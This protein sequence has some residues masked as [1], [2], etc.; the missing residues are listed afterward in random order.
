MM[1]DDE[2][3]DALL[4]VHEMEG[5]ESVMRFIADRRLDRA[6]CLALLASELTGTSNA[7]ADVAHEPI[8]MGRSVIYTRNAHGNLKIAVTT[9]E[10]AKRFADYPL[11]TRFEA[12]MGLFFAGTEEEHEKLNAARELPPEHQAAVWDDVLCARAADVHAGFVAE[13]EWAAL[14]RYAYEQDPNK[15]LLDKKLRA[16]TR[17]R[18]RE[19]SL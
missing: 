12:R 11:G 6:H 15:G 5:T 18:R 7:P 10:P 9:A 4:L 3:G 13:D 19:P 2:L 17:K 16:L 14:Q 1:T 8:A